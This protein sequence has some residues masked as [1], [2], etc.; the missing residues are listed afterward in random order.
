MSDNGMPS[1]EAVAYGRKV[2]EQEIQRLAKAT[3]KGDTEAAERWGS[4]HRWL[5]W[6]VLGD[7]EGCT[8]TAFD[9]RWLD[10]SFRS[11]ISGALSLTP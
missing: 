11:T 2:L 3:E 10:E 1:V 5:S 9:P 4:I 7:G 8:I 6:S